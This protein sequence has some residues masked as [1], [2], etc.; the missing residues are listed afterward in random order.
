MYKLTFLLLTFFSIV[1]FGQADYKIVYNVL[2]NREKDN[3]VNQ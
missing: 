3:S 2:Q 1:C